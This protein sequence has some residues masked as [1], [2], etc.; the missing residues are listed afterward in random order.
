MEHRSTCVTKYNYILSHFIYVLQ[1]LS[2]VIQSGMTSLQM[3]S[4]FGFY[5]IAAYLL[6]MGAK[7][8]IQD[9]VEY[10]EYQV[11]PYLAIAM[12]YSQCVIR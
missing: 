10:L 12:Q 11:L 7:V 8:D 3:A 1:F 6:K 4:Q 5:D 2:Y 9:E